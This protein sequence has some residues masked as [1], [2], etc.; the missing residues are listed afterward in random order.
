VG[1]CAAAPP[2]EAADRWR[3]SGAFS[4]TYDNTTGWSQCVTGATGTASEHV[5]LDVRLGP[6]NANYRRGEP[7]FGVVLKVDIGGRWGLSGSYAPRRRDADGNE[8]CEAPASF[9]CNGGMASVTGKPKAAML[10]VRRGRA[11]AGQFLDFVGVRED[12][13]P[14][15]SCP[16]LAG[17]DSFAVVP[18]LG[19]TTGNATEDIVEGVFTVPVSRL[20]G[21][22]AFTVAVTPGSQNPSECPDAYQTCTQTN[23]LTF[24]LRFTPRR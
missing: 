10:F 20:R 24:T 18:L 7:Q 9:A 8:S 21:R 12:E 19:L 4:G 5:D 6:G 22:R 17:D 2:A 23:R 13:G 3:V 15:E 16:A 1:L 11:F 14:P